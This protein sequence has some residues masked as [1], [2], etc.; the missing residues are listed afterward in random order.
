VVAPPL[1][2]DASSGGVYS[3]G[4]S[5]HDGPRLLGASNPA[6]LAPENSS[7]EPASETTPDAGRTR[8]ASFFPRHVHVRTGANNTSSVSLPSIGTKPKLR[9]GI[10][11]RAA[12]SRQDIEAPNRL[13]Q[14]ARPFR[15]HV[16]R[17]RRPHEPGNPTRRRLRDAA[18]ASV[19]HG[20]AGSS[21][22]RGSRTRGFYRRCVQSG[23]SPP[24]KP[25]K[26]QINHH[27]WRAAGQRGAS[28]KA[29]RH[30]PAETAPIRQSAW[31]FIW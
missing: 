21:S 27:T 8:L 25:S 19:R 22:P 29:S 1:E 24:L 3:S 20:P 26:T 4:S 13:L 5:S 16:A 30:F 12:L 9:R 17:K 2:I 7:A 11:I 15:D 10:S 18:T 31:S 23:R 28:S 14:P 6:A